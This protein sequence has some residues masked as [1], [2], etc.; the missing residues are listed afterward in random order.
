MCYISALDQPTHVDSTAFPSDFAHTNTPVLFFAG[1]NEGYSPFG[2]FLFFPAGS[3][4]SI[5]PTQNC[6]KPLIFC[7]YYCVPVL[8]ITPEHCLQIPH[9]SPFTLLYFLR[10]L[11]HFQNQT[12]CHHRTLFVFYLQGGLNGNWKGAGHACSRWMHGSM[13]SHFPLFPCIL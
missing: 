4:H 2:Y 7:Y 6:V 9:L 10:L 13:E 8:S 12:V 5:Q 3:V 1:Q 11:S